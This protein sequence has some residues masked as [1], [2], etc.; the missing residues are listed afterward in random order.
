MVFDCAKRADCM[1]EAEVN[2]DSDL[3]KKIDDRLGFMTPILKA[4][5]HLF[6]QFASFNFAI[7][8]ISHRNWS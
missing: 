4:G 6:Y 2:G 7:P 5:A 1:E 3:A 8:G